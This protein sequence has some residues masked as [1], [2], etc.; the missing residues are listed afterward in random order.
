M[1]GCCADFWP[2]TLQ[3]EFLLQQRLLRVRAPLAATGLPEG[4]RR[5]IAWVLRLLPMEQL[6][7]GQDLDA[8]E[9]TASRTSFK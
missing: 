3:A 8:W 1:L 7:N 2:A 6:R 5:R 4:G 9:A